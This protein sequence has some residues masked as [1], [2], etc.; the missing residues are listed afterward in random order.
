MKVSRGFYLFILTFGT[1]LTIFMFSISRFH[2]LIWLT[3][4]PPLALAWYIGFKRSGWPWNSN[5]PW[6]SD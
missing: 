1:L 4:I 2:R 3:T 5:W 6:D